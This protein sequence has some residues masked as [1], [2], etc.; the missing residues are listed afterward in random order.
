M[1]FVTALL[2]AVFMSL[3]PSRA[4]TTDVTAQATGPLRGSLLTTGIQNYLNLRKTL[5]P[6][7]WRAFDWLHR[8][9]ETSVGNEV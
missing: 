1:G 7:G 2:V 9:S 5:W 3:Q 8:A 4:I 6:W